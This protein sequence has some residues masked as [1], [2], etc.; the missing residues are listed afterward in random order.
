MHFQVL[1][2]PN[3]EQRLKAILFKRRFAERMQDVE[4]SLNDVL[5]ACTELRSMGKF[6][7][8]LEVILAIGNYMNGGSF[9]GGAFGFSMDTL[10]KLGDTKVAGNARKTLL[11]YVVHTLDT[12][13][14]E[15]ENFEKDIA[16]VHKACKGFL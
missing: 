4:P 8:V 3:Y 10:T 5:A 15:T 13:F 2:I 7:K 12:K 1:Q 6:A 9:R 11:H 14:P 16:A